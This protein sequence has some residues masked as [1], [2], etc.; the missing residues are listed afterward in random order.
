[1]ARAKNN[2]WSANVKTVSTYPPEGLFTKDAKTIARSLASK[3]VSPKGPGSGMRMLAFY[4]NRAGKGLSAER[5]AELEQAKELLS[6]K[7]QA[8]RKRKKAA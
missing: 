1:M 5:K 7:V 2:R 4:I 6:E 8:A 3:K